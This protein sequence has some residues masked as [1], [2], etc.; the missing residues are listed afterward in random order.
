MGTFVNEKLQF[1]IESGLEQLAEGEN[2]NLDDIL[3]G[4]V[5]VEE[6]GNGEVRSVCAEVTRGSNIEATGN[7]IS[8]GDDINRTLRENL[9]SSNVT[10]TRVRAAWPNYRKGGVMISKRMTCFFANL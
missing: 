3:C 1:L 4:S 8:G 2:L 9:G 7:R 5:D 6:G 10:S